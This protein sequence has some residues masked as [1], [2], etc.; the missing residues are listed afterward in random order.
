MPAKQWLGPAGRWLT[1]PRRW[2]RMPRLWPTFASGERLGRY[3][4]AAW[5]WPVAA[6]CY[7]LLIGFLLFYGFAF[8]VLA[9]LTVVP[10]L[11]PPVLLAMLAVWAMPQ[12]R[13]APVK[14]LAT[15]LGAFTLTL[16]IW[17]DYIALSIGSLPWITAAR[18]TGVPMMAI[19]YVAYVRSPNFRAQLADILAPTKEIT[20][21]VALF[22][23]ITTI[24]LPMSKEPGY[25]IGRYFVLFYTFITVFFASAYCFARP[26]RVFTFSIV[27]VIATSI[28]VLTGL[29][30][31]THQHLPWVGHI[32]GFLTIEDP[33]VLKL[34]EGSSRAATGIY[35]VQS[36]FSTS[37]GLGEFFGVAI[38]FMLH[39]FVACKSRALKLF[40]IVL[41][42]AMALVDLQ[43]QSRLAFVCFLSS[44]MLYILFRAM[45]AWRDRPQSLFAPALALSYPVFLALFFV[46]TLVWHRLRIMVWGGGAEQFSTQ[47]RKDQWAGTWPL[48]AKNP[49]GHGLG[50]SGL[51]L[52][53]FAPGSDFPTV[54]SFYISQLL[55]VGILGFLLY[56]AMF[57]AGIARSGMAG[58]KSRDREN[59]FLIAACIAL[60]NFVLAKSVYSQTEN[61]PLAIIILGMVV[62]LTRRYRSE[63]GD[64]PP[65]LSEDDLIAPAATRALH[66][67]GERSRSS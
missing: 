54:D 30:E 35:R 18:L 41:T 51:T 50:E 4:R 11:L 1:A 27:L 52:N 36:K 62:A 47:S 59:Q 33:R 55:D 15:L 39:L 19:L 10:F 53:Y 64:L 17:P 29:Y 45:M 46:A 38:P 25:S 67:D 23:L 12:S 20:W 66:R 28:S 32:P 56:F 58:I 6:L 49:F 16:L 57:A 34:L 26:G 5:P 48:V 65:P 40:L 60:I 7:L 21:F 14:T 22:F 13:F 9:A 2:P 44:F 31:M 63:A 42:P 3:S 24:T 43:T 61:H 37:I 8:G